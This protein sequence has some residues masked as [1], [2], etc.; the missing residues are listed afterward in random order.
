MTTEIEER[1]LQPQPTAVIRAT[2]PI[3][4]VGAALGELLPKLGE[5]LE[6]QQVPVAGAPFTRYL[7]VG[8]QVEIEAGIPVATAVDG[9]GVIAPGELPGGRA[10]VAVYTGP[11]DGLA[12]PHS[13][14]QQ[15][16]TEHGLEPA[17]PP[18]EAYLTGDTG[19]SPG[20]RITEVVYPLDNA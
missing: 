20:Q 17:G 14:I 1:S 9:E 8:E 10:I 19:A 13:A 7:T 15:W 2:A 6:M 18:W 4:H 5:Y 12:E 11:Y 16:L 3:E